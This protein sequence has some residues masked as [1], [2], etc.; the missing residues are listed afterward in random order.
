[1]YNSCCI[2]VCHIGITPPSR[3]I[4]Q[5]ID[6]LKNTKFSITPLEICF[7]GTFPILAMRMLYLSN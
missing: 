6:V 3:K 4:E 5:L 7:E 2:S 1:M